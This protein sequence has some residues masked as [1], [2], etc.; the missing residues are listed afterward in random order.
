MQYI[1]PSRLTFPGI[2]VPPRAQGSLFMYT[3]HLMH[4]I[5]FL[6]DFSMLSTPTQVSPWDMGHRHCS[7][8]WRDASTLHQLTRRRLPTSWCGRLRFSPSSSR[9][10][11]PQLTIT[12]PFSVLRGCKKLSLWKSR[13]TASVLFYPLFSLSYLTACTWVLS[14]AKIIII[15]LSGSHISL[16]LRDMSTFTSES[17]LLWNQ[18]G[19]PAI[20]CVSFSWSTRF[21]WAKVG[22][23]SQNGLCLW[24]GWW[25]TRPLGLLR[26]V[27]YT[28]ESEMLTHPLS[29]LV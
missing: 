15:V 9:R 25:E 21:R 4:Y 27:I 16:S 22:F 23:V 24:L 26:L 11:G 8:L 6:M 18:L 28:Q 19:K 12:C 17:S 2:T 1:P 29:L 5:T 10:H 3:H 20:E 13:L 7:G 14:S